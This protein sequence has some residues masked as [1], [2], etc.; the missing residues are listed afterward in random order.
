MKFLYWGLVFSMISTQLIAE[1]LRD[2][3][4]PEIIAATTGNTA[5]DQLILSAIIISP[6]RHVAV[7]NGTVLKVGDNIGNATI[8]L[9]APNKV[10]L[11]GPSDKITLF[12]LDQS[13]KQ[14]VSG[15]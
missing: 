7:I 14:P 1:E 4:R 9:I 12:L 2:P 15:Y 6:D 13:L 8:V 3:T 11:Q 10:Q 5:Q